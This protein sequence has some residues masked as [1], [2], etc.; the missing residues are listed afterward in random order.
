MDGKVYSYKFLVRLQFRTSLETWPDISFYLPRAII[1][2]YIARG[3]T[4]SEEND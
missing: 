2:L 1:Y 4:D 3:K